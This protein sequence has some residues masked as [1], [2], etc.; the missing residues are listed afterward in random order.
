M[1]RMQIVVLGVS[2]AAFGAAYVLFTSFQTPLQRPQLVVA[3]PK[4][5]LDEVLIASQ[6]IPM[7][8]V[9]TEPLIVWQ[10]WP[11]A[12]V[13]ELMITKSSGP[14]PLEDIKGSMTRT[15]FLH[16]E[17]L[18]RDKIVKAGQGGFMS[19]VLPTGERAVAIRIANS[20]D[21]SAGGFILPNDRV[22]VVQVSRDEDA[23]RTR[24]AEVMG[25][26]TILSNVKVLAIGQTVQEENGKKV[27]VGGN[28]TLELTPDQS[29][30]VIL[31]QQKAGSNLYLL[32]RSLVDSGGPTE[33]VVT[34][35]KGGKGGMTIVRYGAAQQAAR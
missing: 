35:D 31:A 4:I 13:S 15:S 2:V 8:S 6:D 19:A 32:L 3:A 22:D 11:K 27:V 23:T 21:S 1:N 9:I 5:D 29:E 24:G 25:S 7:G 30:L 10:Q 12:A 26:Q 14:N 17:P 34:D 28:A 16:G 33:T 18:R 20:G